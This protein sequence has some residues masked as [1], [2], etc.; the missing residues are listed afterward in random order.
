MNSEIHDT[1]KRKRHQLK[2]A[3]AEV[4]RLRHE[5]RA[6]RDTIAILASEVRIGQP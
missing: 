6:I 4:D 5:C 1:L 3:E 2:A